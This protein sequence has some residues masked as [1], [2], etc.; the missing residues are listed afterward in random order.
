M[1]EQAQFDWAFRKLHDHGSPADRIKAYKEEIVRMK[2]LIAGMTV[3]TD[4]ATA[5]K[6]KQ[7]LAELDGFWN[8]LPPE[9]QQRVQPGKEGWLAAITPMALPDQLRE[10]ETR[11]K[12][13]KDNLGQFMRAPEAPQPANDPVLVAQ[14]QQKQAILDTLVNALP[15]NARKQYAAGMKVM[16]DHDAALP[17]SQRIQ[18][19]DVEIQSLQQAAQYLKAIK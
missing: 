17:I 16:H 3:P 5:E 14:L 4:P 15:D 8:S 6:L 18:H 11:I 1:S 19:L 12:F 7:K 2:A 10:T 13:L 9:Q